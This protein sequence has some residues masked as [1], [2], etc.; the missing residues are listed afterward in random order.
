MRPAPPP[1][2]PTA[3]TET[4]AA[5]ADMAATAETA[6]MGLLDAEED[7]AEDAALPPPVDPPNFLPFSLRRSR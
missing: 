6:V 5:A 4:A 1:G 2:P 3:L 7:V